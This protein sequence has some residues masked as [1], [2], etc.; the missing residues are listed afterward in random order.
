MRLISKNRPSHAWKDVVAIL[1]RSQVAV[2]RFEEVFANSVGA[3]YGIAFPHCRVA[4]Q[5]VLETLSGPGPEVVMPAYTCTAVA[6]ATLLAKKSP[7]FIDIDPI[8]F[9]SPAEKF[10]ERLNKNVGAI[11]P[12]HMYGTPGDLSAL[13]QIDQPLLVLED[14]ALGLQ[15]S[16]EARNSNL[17]VVTVYS[18]G[19]N[20]ILSTVRG[21]IVVTRNREAADVLRAWRREHL[22]LVDLG[23]RIRLCV[24]LLALKT[25]FLEWPY[26]VIDRMRNFS[27]FAR[28][29]DT[30]SLE[31]AEFPPDREYLFSGGQATIGKRQ[32]AQREL[33]ITRRQELAR[34]YTETLRDIPG[35]ETMELVSGSHYSHYAL[36][37]SARDERK[38]PQ[39]MRNAGVEVGRTFDYLVA[40]LPL[41]RKYIDQPLPEA[42]RAVKEVV[43]LPN[44]PMLSD[45]QFERI[46]RAVR[47]ASR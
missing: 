30:R 43:N 6:H 10:L 18:F 28:Y 14:G 13:E 46:V 22:R 1:G 11:I 24:Q 17:T 25:A 3:E 33:F 26:G 32:L 5:A 20:K 12:T 42:R 8:T 45:A 47:M 23:E 37:V 16:W 19:S 31:V 35:V 36:R 38:F 21:G 9:N 40:D 15:K 41:Y 2:S 29:L 34:R 44:Y 7:R 4:M 39:R 27:P